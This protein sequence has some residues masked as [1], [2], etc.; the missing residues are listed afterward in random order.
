ME[1][2]A[3]LAG[4]AYESYRTPPALRDNGAGGGQD[5]AARLYAQ[6]M[7]KYAGQKSEE[8]LSEEAKRVSAAARLSAWYSI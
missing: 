4:K 3:T 5:I 8:R 7:E 2:I 6:Y 1:P